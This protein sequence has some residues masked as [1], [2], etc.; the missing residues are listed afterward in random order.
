MALDAQK[1]P[2]PVSAGDQNGI[3]TMVTNSIRDIEETV[4]DAIMQ[5][6]KLEKVLDKTRY[7]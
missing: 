7:I 5:K 6:K 1:Q 4:T 3:P 2:K